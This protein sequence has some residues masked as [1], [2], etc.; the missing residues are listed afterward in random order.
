MR[1]DKKSL[2]NI[3]YYLDE[4]IKCFEG[5]S[6]ASARA[7]AGL[8]QLGWAVQEDNWREFAVHL[9]WVA[10]NVRE[11]KKLYDKLRPYMSAIEKGGSNEESY[12]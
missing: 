7:A 6:K 2:E 11:M 10:E 8:E 3:I 9:G 1:I 12:S 5:I 4:A